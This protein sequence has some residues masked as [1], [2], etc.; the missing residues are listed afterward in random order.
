MVC[1]NSGNSGTWPL[2]WWT[3]GKNMPFPDISEGNPRPSSCSKRQAKGCRPTEPTKTGTNSASSHHPPRQ[4]NIAEDP[5]F[6][7]GQ[8]H[9]QPGRHVAKEVARAAPATPKRHG[10]AHSR[11]SPPRFSRRNSGRG[12]ST[13]IQTGY[14]PWILL[15]R[16]P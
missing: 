13:P 15:A 1:H 3:G 4:P 14:S 7:F 6:Q 8:S 9:L 12:R 16:S 11:K 2:V 5:R 10:Q